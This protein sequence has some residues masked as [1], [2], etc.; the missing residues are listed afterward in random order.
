MPLKRT[1]I[2]LLIIIINFLCLGKDKLGKTKK[3]TPV[4]SDSTIF[5]E[6][7]GKIAKQTLL[8]IVKEKYDWF[9]IK[10]PENFYGFVYASYIEEINKKKGVCKANNLNIR[11]KPELK[12]PIIGKLKKEDKVKII[13]KVG[14]WYKIKAYPYS[15]GW[16]HKNSI[17]I[18]KKKTPESNRKKSEGKNQPPQE[19]KSEEELLQKSTEE[20]KEQ[21]KKESRAKKIQQIEEREKPVACGV[22]KRE[23][24]LFSLINYKLENENGT[25]FLRI[26]NPLSRKAMKL[27]NKKV[28]IW[29]RFKRKGYLIAEKIL[30]L[31]EEEL[32]AS[33][34]EKEP[35]KRNQEENS[36]IQ[37]QDSRRKDQDKGKNL[38]N[39]EVTKKKK[40]ISR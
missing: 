38:K 14:N 30:L 32:S 26:P 5:S 1:S 9:K 21:P 33:E 31:E 27:I 20:I 24:R 15:W 16:I 3:D 11:A 36:K 29:G 25:I 12:S 18:V 28:E 39:P 40:E 4:R 10:L 7:I 17:E 13:E 34:K 8:E 19:E 6:K 23:N 2:F 37:D 22:L 35:R